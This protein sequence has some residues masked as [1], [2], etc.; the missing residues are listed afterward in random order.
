ME[1]FKSHDFWKKVTYL[2]Q[3]K[4]LNVT[5]FIVNIFIKSQ[6]ILMF[7]YGWRF[8][9]LQD[10]VVFKTPDFLNLSKFCLDQFSK[11]CSFNIWMLL[12]FKKSRIFSKICLIFSKFFQK[13]YFSRNKKKKKWHSFNF[14][15]AR[16]T[17]RPAF[18]LCGATFF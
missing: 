18:R 15:A 2:Y 14:L 5:F 10:F 13:N 17:L 6:K 7:E 11:K 3:Y 4:N 8:Q 9:I 1:P 16:A 12:R